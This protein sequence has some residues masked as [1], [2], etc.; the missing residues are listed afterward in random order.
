VLKLDTP[1]SKALNTSAALIKELILGSAE[2]K[3]KNLVRL[4]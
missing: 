2:I 3:T 1:M 4:F